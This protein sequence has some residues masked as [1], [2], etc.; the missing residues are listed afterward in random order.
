MLFRNFSRLLGV[1]TAALIS[2]VGFAATEVPAHAADESALSVWTRSTELAN[3]VTKTAAKPFQFYIQ[4]YGA[5]AKNVTV[6]VDVGKLDTTRVGYVIP[7]NCVTTT[8]GYTCRLTDMPF[9]TTHTFGAPLYSLGEEGP[10]GT[11]SV[12][13]TGSTP[14]SDLSDNSV[15]VPVT[16]APAGPDLTA[17]AQDVYADAVVD[18]D[19]VDET[20]LTPVKAGHSAVFDWAI[21]NYGSRPASGTIR[22]GFVLPTGTTFAKKP[23]DCQTATS[24]GQTLATCQTP[25]IVLQPGQHYT[26][27]VNVLVASNVNPGALI[28]GSFFIAGASPMEADPQDQDT[29]FEV[30]T[31]R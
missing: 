19:D 11:L 12:K 20:G 22:Y 15:D 5:E 16:V 6:T 1:G 4:S 18:G 25:N 28:G 27:D 24:M 8:G 13:V 23:Q 3:G 17:F 10:A 29:T 26:H 14:E 21:Y 31:R 30:F 9:G 2:A 7:K